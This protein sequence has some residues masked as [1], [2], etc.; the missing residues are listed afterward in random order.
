MPHRIAHASHPRFRPS[1]PPH[2]WNNDNAI[3]DGFQ[4]DDSL[5]ADLL[6]FVASSDEQISFCH[7]QFRMVDLHLETIP[8]LRGGISLR[9]EWAAYYRLFQEVVIK[10]KISA[11]DLANGYQQL[12]EIILP[13]IT[14]M[15]HRGR[16]LTSER[17]LALI[18]SHLT[19]ARRRHH[20]CEELMLRYSQLLDGIE[21]FVVRVGAE[22]S[23]EQ[24]TLVNTLAMLRQ[25]WQFINEDIGLTTS[26]VRH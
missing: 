23:H 21:D 9:E 18:E 2:M 25:D 6:S 12:S 20:E 26:Q 15:T 4:Y 11:A 22:I 17:V 10:K 8:P 16:P 14:T 19:L 3:F 5:R 1:L 24:A 7:R 13:S